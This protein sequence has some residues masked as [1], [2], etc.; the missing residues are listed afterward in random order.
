VVRAWGFEA[1]RSQQ[2]KGTADSADLT[3][4][5]GGIHLE[6]KRDE[7]RPVYN[8]LC[9]ASEQMGEG[10]VAVVLHRKNRQPW[11]VTLRAEDLPALVAR[12]MM[13]RRGT[14]G[15]T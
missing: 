11:Q 6:V 8:A 7:R 15:E 12:F 2:F 1:R 5:L 3:H 10:E 13:A 9:Q 4:T 14:L